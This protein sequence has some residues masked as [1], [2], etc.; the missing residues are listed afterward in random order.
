MPLTAAQFELVITVAGLAVWGALIAG[1][2]F[3]KRRLAFDPK[4]DAQA[5]MLGIEHVLAA[6]FVFLLAASV[7]LVVIAEATFVADNDLNATAV[8][9]MSTEMG[10][11]I[12]AGLMI[13][14]ICRLKV[15]GR[16]F[17]QSGSG[18]A[19]RIMLL[20]AVTYLAIY[21]LVNRLLV[22]LGVVFFDRVLDRTVMPTHSA[23]VLLDHWATTWPIRLT[24]ITSAA[25]TA[26]IA[27]ELFFR[28]LLQNL[29]LKWL[30]RP[31]P[32]IVVASA[33][34]AVMHG[35]MYHQFPALFALSTIL[36]WSYYRCRTLWAP[37]ATHM[38]F[39]AVTVVFW[40]LG[41]G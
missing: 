20:A 29:L 15:I 8:R 14:M 28:G 5:V 26:P 23:L 18:G 19:G 4:P 11:L 33:A 35:T 32:A 21:P 24:A 16:P 41:G 36:G 9:L 34:F 22:D 12:T 40:A 25:V 7:V 38:I 10:K 1:C 37:I 2:A 6:V 31:I 27:E 3:G 39:N 30:R 17:G 13:V